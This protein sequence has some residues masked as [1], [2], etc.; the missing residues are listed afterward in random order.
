MRTFT[1]SIKEEYIYPGEEKV[2]FQRQNHGV[3]T[4]MW[5]GGEYQHFDKAILRI[6]YDN[7]EIPQI[8]AELFMMHGV[9][10]HDSDSF[11]TEILG[12]TG[13][14][15]GLY[16]CFKIPFQNGIKI[17]VQMDERA[18]EKDWF[19][20]I[21]RG[22]DDIPINIGGITLPKSARLKL[23]KNE[24]YNAMPLEEITI[25]NTKAKNGA[26]FL[27]ALSAQSTNF[28]YQESCIRGYFNS[29]EP[30]LISSG[31]EDY[32][33]GTYYFQNG[34]YQNELAGVT[35]LVREKEF[36]GYRFHVS[37]PLFFE[38]NFKLTCRCGE[39]IGDKIF[40]NPQPTR[41]TTYGWAYEW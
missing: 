6:Y 13:H 32:F 3:I 15:G 40:N 7:Q 11:S 12:K 8:E 18:V 34:K 4:H 24:N 17:T 19:W 25:Y 35:H 16:N 5:F 2:I 31:L 1:N 41:Y 27:V 14:P 26:L 9:G 28:E 23:Q 33:L 37:D 38:D 20:S 29:S 39:K 22:T 21:V 30:E 10:F 36:S